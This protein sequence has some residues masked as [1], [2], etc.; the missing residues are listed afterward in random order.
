LKCCYPLLRVKNVI[1]VLQV[2]TRKVGED[3]LKD[4][5]FAAYLATSSESGSD[6][7][8]SNG[9]EVA[10]GGNSDEEPQ[11]QQQQQ[12]QAKGRGKQQQNDGSKAEG[13]DALKAK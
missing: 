1:P 4:G 11:Q 13:A 10:A 9:A 7:G 5:D 2:L 12:Q 8:G 6:D 3:E